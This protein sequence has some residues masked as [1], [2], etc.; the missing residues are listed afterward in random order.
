MSAA[1]HT[2]E[3]FGYPETVVAQN[4]YTASKTRKLAD[5][6]FEAVAAIFFMGKRGM[7]VYAVSS[8]RYLAL[9]E[10]NRA[11]KSQSNYRS[12]LADG[13]ITLKPSAKATG[14]QS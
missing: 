13:R 6:R 2:P 11:I 12:A 7:T 4:C 1:K 3:P 8:S 14:G 5:G 9:K 10:A